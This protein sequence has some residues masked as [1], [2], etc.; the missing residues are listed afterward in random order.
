MKTFEELKERTTP[1]I[2]KQF[3]ELAEGF[4]LSYF[5]GHGDIVTF[6]YNK[7]LPLSV[8]YDNKIVFS[9]LL[10]RAVEGWNKDKK[11]NI[12]YGI[13]VDFDK[14]L[15]WRLRQKDDSFDFKDYLPCHLTACE[16]AIWDCLLEVLR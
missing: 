12:N 1:D 4:E 2:I 15:V 14:I 13:L 5:D 16:M 8:I 6:P 7:T 3:V 10:H 11:D 9:T